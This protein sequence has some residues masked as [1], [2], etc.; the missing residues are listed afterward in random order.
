MHANG[1][2]RFVDI[3]VYA[4]LSTD[5]S[6]HPQLPT[7]STGAYELSLALTAT[8]LLAGGIPEQSIPIPIR[9]G[10][11]GDE[12]RWAEQLLGWSGASTQ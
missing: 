4:T 1:K 9:L 3:R 12:V 7:G 8:H 5:H 10:V 6:D 2:R 11:S